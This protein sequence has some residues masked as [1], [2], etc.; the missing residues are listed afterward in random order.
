MD[1]DLEW[2]FSGKTKNDTWNPDVFRTLD[3]CPGLL[4]FRVIDSIQ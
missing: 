4:G 3:G 1:Q 2:S